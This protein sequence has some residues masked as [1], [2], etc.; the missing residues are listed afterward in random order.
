MPQHVQH[1]SNSPILAEIRFTL[2]SIGNAMSSQNPLLL[3]SGLPAFDKILPEHVAPAVSEILQRS[4]QL[5]AEA[6]AAALGDWDALMNP[7]GPPS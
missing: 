5:L 6:E 7:L 2:F 1:A 4:T 3:S